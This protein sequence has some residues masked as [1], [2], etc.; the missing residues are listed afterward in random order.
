MGISAINPATGET[1]KH[2]DELTP[3]QVAEIIE[4][5]HQ[6]FQSWKITCFKERSALMK[7]AAQSL[8]DDLEIHAK[9]MAEEMGKPITAGRAEAEKCAWVCDYYAENAE[10]FLKDEIIKTDASK[11]FVTFQPIG[12]VLAVMPWNFPFWQVYRFA[13]PAL[14]AGNA[15]LL[16]HASNVFGCALAIE[17]TFHKAGF[18]KE[19]FRTLLVGS[20]Q[21]G[22]VIENPFVKAVTLTGSTPAR[23]RHTT[24]AVST[25]KKCC[26]LAMRR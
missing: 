9:L 4:Q 11:S 18:P 25:Y 7:K 19:V 12:I 21:V 2:Y 8:R 17:E 26:C 1:I 16:K 22:A 13:A 3:Q 20:Q 15:G 14:M 10:R 5:A 6:A 24:L 23:W